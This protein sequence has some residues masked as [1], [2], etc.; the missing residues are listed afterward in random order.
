MD[1]TLI[2]ALIS[3]AIAYIF[4]LPRFN[5]WPSEDFIPLSGKPKNY[6]RSTPYFLL[7]TAYI[8]SILLFAYALG[9]LGLLIVLEQAAPGETTDGAGTSSSFLNFLRNT[10]G[11]HALPVATVL[12]IGSIRVLPQ[13]KQL[14][15][16]WRAYLLALARVPKDAGELKRMILAGLQHRLP[17]GKRLEAVINQLKARDVC[18][19]WQEFDTQN[20][21]V[22][23]HNE[24]KTLLIKNLHLVGANRSFD[25]ISTESQYLLRAEELIGSIN[26]PLPR[27]DL[28]NNPEIFSRYKNQLNKNLKMLAEMLAR[29]TVKTHFKRTTQVAK[30]EQL[31]LEVSYLDEHDLKQ[32]ILKPGVTIILGLLA[33]NLI[34][35]SLGLLLFDSLKIAPPA[36]VDGWFDGSRVLRWSLGSW[37]SQSVAI[38]FGC[39]FHET[40]AKDSP[41]AAPLA[42]LLAL[43]FATLGSGLYFIADGAN[44][45]V[46][47]ILLSIS[48]GL[49]A[50]VTMKSGATYSFSSR[51]ALKTAHRISLIYALAVAVLQM[52]VIINLEGREVVATSDALAWFVFGSAKGY[53]TA[54][55]VTYTL[56]N[57]ST[58]KSFEG[59]RK[60]PRIPYFKHLAG[61]LNNVQ[62]EILVKNISCGGALVR[63][64]EGQI[65]AEGQRLVLNFDFS[66]ISGVII[67]AENSLARLRFDAAAPGT[68]QLKTHLQSEVP[69]D[70]LL[71]MAA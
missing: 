33:V 45:S 56:L 27:L 14:D 16:K 36:H 22:G 59:R 42:Y 20:P 9:Q 39:F 71:V 54:F 52:L 57:Y 2:D 3:L 53:F 28:E 30:M 55:L 12:I 8:L 66:P 38:F 48:F 51:Q 61:Q 70:Y 15:D 18:N 68:A 60:S 4:L 69:A 50:L 13:L 40:L 46:S 64:P 37:M 49:M 63:F 10:Y 41:I 6:L 58:R 23:A 44:F 35:I 67:W 26:S 62:T 24:L 5:Q 7:G 21:G 19:Y 11:H 25:L 1:I 34:I 32:D 29:N 65:P 43:F 31:G 47:Q 17:Q